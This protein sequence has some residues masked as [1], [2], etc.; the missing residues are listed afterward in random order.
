MPTIIRSFWTA[1]APGI[2]EAAITAAAKALIALGKN[3]SDRR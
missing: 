1:A 3:L 2:R